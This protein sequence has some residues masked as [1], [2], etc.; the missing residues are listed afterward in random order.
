[1]GGLQPLRAQLASE[2]RIAAD[3]SQTPS[4][5]SVARSQRGN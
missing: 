1:L 5:R 3:V 4:P 2:M